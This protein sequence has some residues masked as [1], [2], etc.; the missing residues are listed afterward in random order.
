MSVRARRASTQAVQSDSLSDSLAN[1]VEDDPQIVRMQR[2]LLRPHVHARA[3]SPKKSI[4]YLKPT[5]HSAPAGDR[6]PIAKDRILVT[7]L[8]P[9]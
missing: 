1:D 9:L 2:R 5:V 4:A 6:L 7:W 3:P 8:V